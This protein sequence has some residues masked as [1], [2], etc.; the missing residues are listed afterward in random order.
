[1]LGSGALAAKLRH[2]GTMA[3]KGE[4]GLIH[5]GVEKNQRVRGT[6]PEVSPL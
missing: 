6:R 1:M 5:G 2:G 3:S 4:H